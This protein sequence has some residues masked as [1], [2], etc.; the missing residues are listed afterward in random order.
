[1]FISYNKLSLKITSEGSQTHSTS[2]NSKIWI[3]IT[4]AFGCT[5]YPVMQIGENALKHFFSIISRVNAV[6]LQW[7]NSYRYNHVFPLFTNLSFICKVPV[8]KELCFTK[9]VIRYLL[10]F[11]FCFCFFCKTCLVCFCLVITSHCINVFLFV[12]LSKIRCSLNSK[13]V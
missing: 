13:S 1:M 5:I 12:L 10:V 4:Q 2:T 6:Q 11:L 7:N 3:F 9:A 8:T